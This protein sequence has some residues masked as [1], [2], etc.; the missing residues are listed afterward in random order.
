MKDFFDFLS[1]L[2][3]KDPITLFL[4]VLILL[5]FVA[6][7]GGVAMIWFI[8]WRER[9]D[10]DEKSEM[11]ALIDFGRALLSEG[12]E[13]RNVTRQFIAE[14]VE[15]R[16]TIA[17]LADALKSNVDLETKRL[18]MQKLAADAQTQSIQANTAKLAETNEAI[19]GLTPNIQQALKQTTARIDTATQEGVNA[20]S[21][22]IDDEV[23][24]LLERLAPVLTGV[25]ASEQILLE[26]K[27]AVGALQTSIQELKDGAS[28]AAPLAEKV[29]RLNKSLDDFI[30]KTDTS[31]KAIQEQLQKI[32]EGLIKPV[33]T[34]AEASAVA[35]GEPPK[36]AEA[37]A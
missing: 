3:D 36:G 16:R 28:T 27:A 18:D 10:K 15:N 26:I 22:K 23:T 4:F 8:K 25:N 30:S 5:S 21:Q 13:D 24:K 14:S 37:M 33:S 11:K 34:S 7:L 20:V 31:F 35:P 9:Q 19:A 12:T 6:L 1:K 2:A 32:N 17:S 29:V